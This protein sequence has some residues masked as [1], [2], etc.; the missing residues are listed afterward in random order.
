MPNQFFLINE[1]DYFYLPF[2]SGG[3]RTAWDV[4]KAIALGADG[5]VICVAEMAA[6][7]CIDA[8]IV[9]A[10]AAVPGE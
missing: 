5:E 10:V 3:L 6:L 8:E 1:G 9:K 7:G 2:A 4:A